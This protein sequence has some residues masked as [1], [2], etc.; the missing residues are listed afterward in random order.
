MNQLE[1]I[2]LN[3]LVPRNHIY[4][5]FVSI[6]NFKN[7]AKKLKKF[8]KDNPYKGYGMLRLFKCL[9]L[10]FMEDLSDREL[11][12]YLQENNAAKWFCEF[13]LLEK[14]P[15]HSVFC[16][17]RKNIGTRFISEIFNDL[18]KQLKQQGFI[19]EVF[20][21][22]DASH[23]IAKAN[24]WKERDKAIKEKYEKLNNEIL[25]KVAIDK[26]A[27][28]GCKGKDKFWYGY[29]KHTSVD[30]QSGLI[31]KVAVTP[32]NVT[33]AKGIK[34]V[35]PDGGAIYADKGYC[36]KYAN[37]TAR[38]NCCDLK[39]IKKNNMLGKNHDQDSWFSA[40]RSPYER[41]FAHQDKRVRYRGVSKNHF[42]EL[43]KSICFNL[44]RLVVLDPLN[45]CLN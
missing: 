33:D 5:K 10:Q 31:N 16:K 41:V 21:F 43:M 20:S 14:T 38:D 34:Y 8:E 28:I 22:V 2:S 42:A 40:I 11:E 15:D 3:D 17:F 26:Q 7:V 36:T 39:A 25:P 18:R 12:K 29:K 6:W 19:N 1:M 24:L 23:L 35:C 4:R 9:L 30:M 37:K 13:T 32:A 44:K 27:R 45:L